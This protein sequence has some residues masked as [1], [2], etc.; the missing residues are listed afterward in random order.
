M[1]E[2]KSVSSE[3]WIRKNLTRIRGQIASGD[4]SELWFW[5]IP[6]GLA[7]SQR[8]LRDT[9]GYGGRSPLTPGAK[10]LVIAWVDHVVQAGFRSVIS[11][12]EEAQ[13]ERYYIRGGLNLH[14][15]GLF[16]YLKERGL[17]V[18]WIPCKDYQRPTLGQM[19]EALKEYQR[20]GKPVLMFCSAGID[21]TTPVAAFINDRLVD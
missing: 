10:A 8:P 16:G 3:K 21:R 7:C 11:L 9:P 4:D 6:A 2:I 18:V 17:S 12:M 5:V 19:E 20:L 14:P 1:S 15:E 13:H